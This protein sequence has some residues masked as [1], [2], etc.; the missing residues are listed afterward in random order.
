VRVEARL[1]L[2]LAV[3]FWLI[4]IGYG[5]WTS[6]T[7]QHVEVVGVAGLILTGGLVGIPGGFFWFV[8]RRID[9][10]PEDRS[11]A[12][13]AEAAGEYGFFSPG[14]YWPV[15]LAGAATLVGIALAFAQ[16]WLVIVALLFLFFM[17]GGLLFEYYLGGNRPVHPITRD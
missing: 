5:V 14:S 7:Q 1:F 10:R 8:S 13:I 12:E 17:V 9:P 11:D 4:A 6:V 16:V 15:G 2:G 3:F